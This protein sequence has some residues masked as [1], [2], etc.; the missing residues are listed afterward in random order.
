MT[1]CL[2]E[3]QAGNTNQQYLIFLQVI[4]DQ[5]AKIDHKQASIGKYIQM[6]H[7]TNIN[8]LIVKLMSSVKLKLGHI[9][10]AN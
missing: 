2:N 1:L 3:L 6:T 7:Y 5:L 9:S 8:E 4:N 10:L